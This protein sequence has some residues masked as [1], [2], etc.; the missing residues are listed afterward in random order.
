MSELLVGK[1]TKSVIAYFPA[2]SSN[3]G[4][5]PIRSSA[6]YSVL[7]SLYNQAGAAAAFIAF[8]SMVVDSSLFTVLSV[9]FRFL[10]Q[11]RYSGGREG[12][13]R[14]QSRKMF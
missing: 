7:Q 12:G 8:Q 2:N 13:G 5:L 9:T 11:V 3:N 4:E 1:H 14:V 10:I 6:P